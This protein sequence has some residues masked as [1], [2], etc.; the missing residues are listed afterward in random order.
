MSPIADARTRSRLG[1]PPTTVHGVPRSGSRNFL[2]FSIGSPFRQLSDIP[3]DAS[4]LI[5]SSAPWQPS[6]ARN[7]PTRAEFRAVPS[8]TDYSQAGNVSQ[9]LVGGG[10]FGGTPSL[11][12]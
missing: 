7:G 5:E 6:P 8:V 3:Y 2:S 9:R 1:S 4:S 11:L 12:N 10:P